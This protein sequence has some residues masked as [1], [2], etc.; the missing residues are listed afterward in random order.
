MNLIGHSKLH[1]LEILR[2]CFFTVSILTILIPS[3]ATALNYSANDVFF[4]E[5]GKAIACNPTSGG[6]TLSGS[7]NAEKAWN[8]L[9]SKGISDIVIAAMLGNWQLESGLI[10]T[11]VEGGKLS[12]TP[13]SRGGYGLMQWTP[14]KDIN[15][16]WTKGIISVA[17]AAKMPAGPYND[18]AFQLELAYKIY[19][20][21][22][23]GYSNSFIQKSKD[24]TSVEDMASLYMNE[25]ER[26]GILHED[27]RR[28]YARDFLKLYSKG[29][30]SQ[31]TTPLNPL[32][33]NNAACSGGG[34]NLGWDGSKRPGQW[35]VI[36]DGHVNYQQ[37]DPEWADI[38][39]AN[40][41]TTICKSA[42]GPFAM[43][44]VIQNFGHNVDPSKIALEAGEAGVLGSNGSRIEDVVKY[45][46]PKYNLRYETLPNGDLNAIK[47]ALNKGAQVILGGFGPAPWITSVGHIESVWRYD[48]QK[49][50][51]SISDS[52]NRSNSKDWPT[53]QVLKGAYNFYGPSRTDQPAV[54]V[55]KQ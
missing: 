23:P 15:G 14:L 10:P 24:I 48:D 40:G 32:I 3:S 26:P 42:C 20:G 12:D 16:N 5:P 33:S 35:T 52:G 34:G 44:N 6:T 1:A 13:P 29:D 8:F 2:K 4:Y 30:S 43:A 17:E 11:K 50:T 22:V 7:D 18:L 39:V 49:N 27:K 51:L 46:A 55:Y 54:A 19:L 9:K 21:N 36:A 53:D 28:G 37:C 41:A 25:V 45:F 38:K 31:P 47:M